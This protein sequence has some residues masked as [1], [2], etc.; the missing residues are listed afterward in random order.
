MGLLQI[1]IAVAEILFEP[2]IPAQGRMG[3]FLKQTAGAQV[4]T[5]V[6]P[7]EA[8]ESCIQWAY[9]KGVQRDVLWW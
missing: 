1:C 2:E 4:H 6:S 9:P 3:H 8:L 7:K 5:V